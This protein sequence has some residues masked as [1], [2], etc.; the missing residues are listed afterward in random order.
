MP[1]VRRC[2]FGIALSERA[3]CA[4]DLDSRRCR[5]HRHERRL[6]LPAVVL[7]GAHLRRKPLCRRRRVC[8]KVP[9]VGGVGR[10]FNVDDDDNDGD[11]ND[12]A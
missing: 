11:D 1:S 2:S 12:D 10:R 4:A 5:C 6:L 3:L 7:H 8:A 9:G